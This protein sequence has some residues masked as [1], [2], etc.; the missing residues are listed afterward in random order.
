M[1]LINHIAKTVREHRKAAGLSQADL[2]LLAGVGR[3][4]VFEIEK[5]KE[6]TRI[7]SVIKVLSALNIEVELNSPFNDLNQSTEPNL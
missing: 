3:S 1:E 2:A 6:S 7:S 4:S 5:G